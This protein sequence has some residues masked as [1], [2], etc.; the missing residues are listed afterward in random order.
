MASSS[1]AASTDELPEVRTLI[2]IKDGKRAKVGPI[3]KLAEYENWD[4]FDLLLND[5]DWMLA[6]LPNK[7]RS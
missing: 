5:P 3:S 6:I 4:A 1:I 2:N 7:I